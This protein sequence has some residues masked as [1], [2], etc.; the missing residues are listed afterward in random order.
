MGSG[1][2]IVGGILGPG[3]NRETEIYSEYKELFEH[4]VGVNAFHSFGRV[5]KGMLSRL[6]ASGTSGMFGMPVGVR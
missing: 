6:F 4:D 3:R 5:E 1:A 2:Q